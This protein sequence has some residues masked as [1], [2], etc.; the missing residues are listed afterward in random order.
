MH[1]A[2]AATPD[3]GPRA[4]GA[5][6][7]RPLLG[8][9]AREELVDGGVPP[10][11]PGLGEG[12]R[13]AV[14]HRRLGPRPVVD[15][16]AGHR[17]ADQAEAEDERHGGGDPSARPAADAARRAGRGRGREGGRDRGQRVRGTGRAGVGGGAGR[18][19]GGGRRRAR[20][21]RGRGRGG[22]GG[23]RRGWRRGPRRYRDVGGHRVGPRYGRDARRR[24]GAARGRHGG[25]RR[26]G[27]WRNGGCRARGGRS[28]RRG[29]RRNGRPGRQVA[30][31]RGRRRRPSGASPR[32]WSVG[33][34]PGGVCPLSTPVLTRRPLVTCTCAAC[35]SLYGVV[36]GCRCH[37]AP[38]PPLP[39]GSHGLAGCAAMS[40]RTADRTRYDRATAH[41]DAPAGDRGPGGVRRERR[42][43]GPP[44]RREAGPGRLEVR[45]LPCAARTR[46]GPRRLRRADVLH[47]GGV[48]V[49][50]PGGLHGRAARVPVGRPGRVRGAGR[51]PQAGRGR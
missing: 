13:A 30:A 28:R 26:N 3:P 25:P 37:R 27:P 46:A 42:R 32:G 10:H 16:G 11:R 48:A 6:G 41:L 23:G 2:G 43:P 9:G 22:R 45:P 20:D 8:E 51:R 31:R 17:A 1:P 19:R 4:V 50:G 44:R 18:I 5:A 36:A 12:F 35:A 14:G 34:G 40:D 33:N 49:A 29:G 47:A 39:R 24:A 21:V 15:D 7:S 38:V